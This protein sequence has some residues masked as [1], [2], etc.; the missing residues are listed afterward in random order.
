MTTAN[1][2]SAVPDGA[3]VFVRNSFE[4]GVSMPL[5]RHRAY[6]KNKAFVLADRDDAVR[7][8]AENN[9]LLI[10]DAERSK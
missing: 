9:L 7:Y 5:Y 10:H 3:L 1:N 6:Q 2:S 8:A 4:Y